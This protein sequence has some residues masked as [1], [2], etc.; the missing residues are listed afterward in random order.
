ML[1]FVFMTDACL[2]IRASCRSEGLD[3]VCWMFSCT[4]SILKKRTVE[5]QKRGEV[6][7]EEAQVEGMVEQKIPMEIERN[8]AFKRFS[9]ELIS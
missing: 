4:L 3:F 7:V 8:D 9:L 2:R 1:L 5:A 6:R